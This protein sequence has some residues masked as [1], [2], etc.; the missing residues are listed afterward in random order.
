MRS[1]HGIKG[2]LVDGS[3]GQRYSHNTLDDNSQHAVNKCGEK[4]SGEKENVKDNSN[5]CHYQMEIGKEPEDILPGKGTYAI[6][7]AALQ[8]A[9]GIHDEIGTGKQ[10]NFTVSLFPENM[11]HIL[12]KVFRTAV[13]IDIDVPRII[14]ESIIHMQRSCADGKIRKIL[15]HIVL[16]AM[17]GYHG[18]NIG[19]D[20]NYKHI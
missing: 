4:V 12:F 6:I 5:D 7:T 1:N 10:G 3:K 17:R 2:Q 11:H 18:K 15:R 8:T 14:P 9:V 19:N 20:Q 16:E 13:G